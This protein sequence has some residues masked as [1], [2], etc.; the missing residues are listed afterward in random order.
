[1]LWRLVG[2]WVL[3][4]GDGSEVGRSLGVSFLVGG[5]RY[6]GSSVLL[7]DSPLLLP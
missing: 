7:S 1:V 6:S 4:S 3:A 2:E 5:G